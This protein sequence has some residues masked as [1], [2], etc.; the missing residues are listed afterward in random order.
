MDKVS[1]KKGSV[2]EP[3]MVFDPENGAD[4]KLK[5]KRHQFTGRG[6]K[7]IQ[8]LNYDTSEFAPQSSLTKEQM[9]IVEKGLHPLKEF[10]D[11]SDF[12]S[13][14]QLLNLFEKKTGMKAQIKPS[15]E[16]P[17]EKQPET[18]LEDAPAPEGSEGDGDDNFFS[19][20]RKKAQA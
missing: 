20:L 10:I 1:P 14:D 6:G 15:Q 8:S 3:V 17:E 5:V 16:L 12:K 2:D 4:F 19:G 7:I 18:S 11:R 9:E 13:Y